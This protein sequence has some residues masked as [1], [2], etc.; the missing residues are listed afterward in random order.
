MFQ[1]SLHEPEVYNILEII[2]RSF[3]RFVD[4]LSSMVVLCHAFSSV[5]ISPRAILQAKTMDL[6][7]S[8]GWVIAWLNSIQS[9]VCFQHPVDLIDDRRRRCAAHSRCFQS[10]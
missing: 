4:L 1:R 2:F 10:P 9:S 3:L 8:E 7:R 5:N 6:L